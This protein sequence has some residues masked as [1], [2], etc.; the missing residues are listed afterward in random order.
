MSQIGRDI[1]GCPMRLTSRGLMNINKPQSWDPGLEQT[2][3]PVW[4]EGVTHDSVISAAR[5]IQDCHDHILRVGR[6]WVAAAGW[7]YLSAAVSTHGIT[8]S[9]LPKPKGL[10]PLW[11]ALT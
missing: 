10:S 5:P 1:P 3:L 4:Y 2:V 9:A 11:Q 8:Y 7:G 6:P